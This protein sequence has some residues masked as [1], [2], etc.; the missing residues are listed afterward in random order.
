M[1][2]IWKQLGF[3]AV[4]GLGLP[5]L[6]VAWAVWTNGPE[7][8]QTP[9]PE[10]T[11]APESTPAELSSTDQQTKVSVLLDDSDAV[12][13]DMQTYLTGVV[14]AEM[15]ASFEL[16]ALKAQA[17]VARTY[18]LKRME[19][20]NKHPGKQICTNPGC[21]QGY[22]SAED[23]LAADGPQ[24]ALDKVRK[25]VEQTDGL[26]LTYGDQLIDAT[27]FSCSG[28]STEDAVAVWGAEVPYLQA[29]DSPGEEHAVHNTDSELF[30]AASFAQLL[31]ADLSGD[32]ADWFGPVTYTKGGGVDT[33]EIGGVVYRGTTLRSQLGLRSTDFT[34]SVS[35]DAITI[36]THGFGHR[37]GMSQY[38][39][40]AMAAAGST[41]E[42]ILA[43]Y[44]QGTSLEVYSL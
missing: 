3:A 44:Y 9:E 2:Q 39:A 10:I 5:A 4:L 8:F 14:L 35:G 26:V 28:G 25:A 24:D 23:Y 32:P 42:E 16:E 27:Y 11:Q 36:T 34:V 41:C 29:T 17:I 1:K 31:G 18:A 30:S 22:K 38:G 15:P 21:C 7:T 20:S 40:D 6:A 19:T 37:V 13:L 33:M 43:H 12:Q